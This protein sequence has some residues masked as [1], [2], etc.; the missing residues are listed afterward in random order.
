MDIDYFAKCCGTCVH[1]DTEEMFCKKADS[2]TALIS[3]CEDGWEMS[4][5]F[6]E[7]DFKK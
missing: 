4:K 5:C 3:V 7:D 6:N 1:L 2:I